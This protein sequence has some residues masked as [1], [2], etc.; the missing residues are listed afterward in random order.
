MTVDENYG[1]PHNIADILRSSLQ[2]A[3]EDERSVAHVSVIA[4]EHAI[5]LLRNLEDTD[6]SP[7]ECAEES[8]RTGL[9][10]DMHRYIFHPWR[11]GLSQCGLCVSMVKDDSCEGHARFHIDNGEFPRVSALAHSGTL[12]VWAHKTTTGW[13]MRPLQRGDLT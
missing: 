11:R 7:E 12:E 8:E 3:E 4:L 9:G 10:I 2:S 6:E 1:D 5:R 13:V